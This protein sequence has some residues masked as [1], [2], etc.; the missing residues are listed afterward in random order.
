M[1]KFTGELKILQ[2]ATDDHGRYVCH[3]RNIAGGDQAAVLVNVESPAKSLNCRILP[4]KTAR[5]E[6]TNALG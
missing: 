2:L 5:D 6:S 3:A 4:I 1:N